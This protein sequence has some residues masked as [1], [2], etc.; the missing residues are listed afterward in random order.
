MTQKIIHI[1]DTHFGNQNPTYDLGKIQKLLIS[2]I[3][4][5][6]GERFLVISGD[7]TFKASNDGYTQASDF[8]REIIIQ[9]KIPQS[10]VIACPGNHDICPGTSPFRNF[11]Q[12]IYS[13]RR[14]NAISFKKN[15]STIIAAGETVFFLINS[16]HHCDHKFGLIPLDALET[17][18][19]N[20]E[21]F[22]RFK[23]RVL[24]THH[25]LIGIH[26]SDISTTR[27]AYILLHHLDQLNFDY[28]LHG[29]QH[30][31]FDFPVG[32][33]GMKISSARSLSYHDRGFSNGI[34]I[35]D[36]ETG[37]IEYLVMSPDEIPGQ[38]TTGVFNER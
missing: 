31:K 3:N 34:N 22:E 29:H 32:K 25:H 35:L 24:I 14:D 18:T 21:I 38:L 15:C 20:K 1:S 30:S 2:K 36:I 9:C 16:A 5:I 26:D 27:N 8:F 11:D 10:N 37:H 13:L 17:L 4:K 28:I 7:I 33:S 19:T 6:D 23:K 12:F